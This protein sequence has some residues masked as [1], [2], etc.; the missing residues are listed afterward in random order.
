MKKLTLTLLLI[1]FALTS[2]AK[3]YD[4]EFPVGSSV[5]CEEEQ[6]TGFNWENNRWKKVTFEKERI[7][8]KKIDRKNFDNSEIHLRNCKWFLEEHL[9][10]VKDKKLETKNKITKDVVSKA[11]PDIQWG[12][13]S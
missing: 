13:R 2:F 1:L 10:V 11:Y 12:N 7:I 6:T 4:F 5:Y 8:I 3:E 9:E